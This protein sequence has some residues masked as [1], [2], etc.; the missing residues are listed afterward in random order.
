MT[1]FG[2]KLAKPMM[3]MVLAALLIFGL[4]MLS[5]CGRSDDAAQQ[6]AAQTTRSGEA[7]ANAAQAA[8]EVIGERAATEKTVDQATAIAVKGV[9]DAQD[10]DAVR[11]VVVASLC[12]QASHRLDPACA[13]R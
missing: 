5:H 13:V 10:P 12:R 7:V 4:L 9:E 8:I 3:F 11:A 6:Q 2:Y 1:I